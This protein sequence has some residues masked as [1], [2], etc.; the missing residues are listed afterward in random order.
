MKLIKRYF[1]S[2]GR[3]VSSGQICQI[4]LDSLMCTSNPYNSLCR[5][6]WWY[7]WLMI[8]SYGYPVPRAALSSCHPEFAHG[9]SNSLW[10]RQTTRH[11]SQ[12]GETTKP[13]SERA[14]QATT[15]GAECYRESVGCVVGFDLGTHCTEVGC[16][17]HSAIRWPTNNLW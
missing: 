8:L 17:N 9:W 16:P 3:C 14:M 13:L 12:L 11:M 2:R 10:W 1:F 6:P 7:W 15:W 5:H 4:S